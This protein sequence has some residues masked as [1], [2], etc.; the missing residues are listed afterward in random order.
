LQVRD[1]RVSSFLTL[2]GNG[3]GT[4]LQVSLPLFFVFA[5]EFIS[6]AIAMVNVWYIA[7]DGEA[8]GPITP[9]EFADFIRRRQLLKSDYVWHDGLGDWFLAEDLLAGYS[10]LRAPQ[11]VSGV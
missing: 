4:P 3:R 6:W 1:D 11:H 7:R 10:A 5:D 8:H 9:A 2:F